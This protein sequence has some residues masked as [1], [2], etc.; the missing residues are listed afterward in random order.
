MVDGLHREMPPDAPS[1]T[2]LRRY[3]QTIQQIIDGPANGD[4]DISQLWCSALT[5][6]AGT[7]GS[8][9]H[10]PAP[11]I[12]QPLISCHL[13][14]CDVTNSNCEEWAR[15]HLMYSNLDSVAMGNLQSLQNP[16]RLTDERS[17]D[18]RRSILCRDSGREQENQPETIDPA[19]FQGELRSPGS[20]LTEVQLDLDTWSSH[21]SLGDN[22]LLSTP[23]QTD[24]TLNHGDNL[25]QCRSIP[26]GAYGSALSR[27]VVRR[28]GRTRRHSQ[29]SAK[30]DSSLLKTPYIA[31]YETIASPDA[32]AR[33][34]QI[35]SSSWEMPRMWD[36]QCQPSDIE[37]VFHMLDELEI[38]RRTGTLWRRVL[39]FRLSQYRHKVLTIVQNGRESS[40]TRSRIQGKGRP[41]SEA[42]DILVQRLYP[43]D[44]I[45]NDD[46]S[47]SEWRA[48][49]ATKRK[50][51]TNR[52]QAAKNWSRAVEK[53]ELGIL[54]L[55][56]FEEEF[57]AQSSE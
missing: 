29:T 48:K 11:M 36:L 40:P 17:K 56:P 53:L 26:I 54:A 21:T 42:L 50:R 38:A 23:C 2:E 33:L 14:D 12:T 20:I 44:A 35:I 45:P 39:L 16:F 57:K 43:A 3:V 49:H 31:L 41:E 27:G 55:V 18:S 9:L 15:A 4:V 6:A 24:D 51:I 19:V 8:S 22:S 30:V 10:S 32:L 47:V 7:S 37:E 28:R 13:L 46:E 34:T 1:F 52:L 5:T 25:S